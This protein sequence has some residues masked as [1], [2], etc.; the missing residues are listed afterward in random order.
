[1]R[2]SKVNNPL[3]CAE[4]E[5]LCTGENCEM[6]SKGQCDLNPE[7]YKLWLQMTTPLKHAV[8]VETACPFC[9]EGFAIAFT[10]LQL[11]GL[12]NKSKRLN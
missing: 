2:T 3:Y 5:K 8:Q 7:A 4:L 12:Y 11:K 1:M 6:I 9:L 10:R